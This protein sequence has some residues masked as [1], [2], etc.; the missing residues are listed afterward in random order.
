MINFAYE[1]LVKVACDC[2]QH[3]GHEVTNLISIDKRKRIKGF[4]ADRFIK[5]PVN[6][7]LMFSCNI[8]VL[9]IIVNPSVGSQ[10]SAGIE[11]SK[12][13]RDASASKMASV[14]AD[15]GTNRLIFSRHP[16]A[17][18]EVKFC[19]EQVVSRVREMKFRIYKTVA[20]T[21]PA[22][23]SLEIWGTPSSN[24]PARVLS[25]INNLWKKITGPRQIAACG[26][27]VEGSR[28]SKDGP[29]KKL[30]V[31]STEVSEQTGVIVPEEFVD[32]ISCE[33]MTIPMILPSGN[34]VDISTLEKFYAAEAKQGRGRSDPFTG[35]LFGEN[36]QPIVATALKSRLDRFLLDHS[37]DPKIRT[38][39]R[40]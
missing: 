32:P 27:L 20:S 21:L 19:N 23:S 16:E 12:T 24:V 9:Q 33:I 40:T 31:D 37:N 17:E 36:N 3:D 11:L 39:P 1:G 15:I 13:Q 4:L 35:V 34:M 22:L 30:H 29:N 28:I 6:I 5:P 26:R 14:D 25:D 18:G 2:L 10:R 7:T 8:D 38:L